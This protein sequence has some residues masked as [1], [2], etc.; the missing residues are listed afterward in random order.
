M[1]NQQANRE[2]EAWQTATDLVELVNRKL[3]QFTAVSH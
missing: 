3:A 2:S 1:G